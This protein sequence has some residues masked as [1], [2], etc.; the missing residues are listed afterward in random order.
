MFNFVQFFILI[1]TF[2]NLYSSVEIRR[3]EYNDNYD[4]IFYLS[5]SLSNSDK[6]F[7]HIFE[8]YNDI[9]S[10][11][12]KM[13]FELGENKEN[14]NSYFVAHLLNEN[15]IGQYYG[16][17]IHKFDS[18]TQQFDKNII[19]ADPYSK[20]VVTQNHYS[21]I[22]KSIIVDMQFDWQGDKFLNIDS[23]NLIIYEAHLKDMTAHPTSGLKNNLA[24]TYLGFID[25]SQKGGIKHLKEM[26]YNAVEFLPVFDFANVEIPF[27]DSSQFITNTWNPYE[28]NHWGYMPSFFFAP[29]GSYASKN[30]KNRGDWNGIHGQQISEFKSVIKKLH[31]NGIA[32]ILDVVYNHVSQYDFNPLKQID[33]DGFFRKNQKGDYSS[34]SGCGND[35]KTENKF[36]RNLILK[37]IK[38]WMEEY[39]I[40]GFRFDLESYH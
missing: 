38:Y 7:L 28:E 11:K 25:Q 32:I 21:P 23:R 14:Y 6:V 15:L 29:E 40:D 36:I 19:I 16:F 2:G 27:Q 20:A 22:N 3:S 34:I 10:R 39:H 1:F 33:K 31:Q 26:G 35:L 4:T 12:I 13:K 18:K 17:E 8:K 9:N 30:S 37:S 24:G 5:L